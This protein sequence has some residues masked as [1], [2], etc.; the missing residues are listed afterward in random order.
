MFALWSSPNHIPIQHIGIQ[1]RKQ[2]NQDPFLNMSTM[3]HECRL[4]WKTS[5]LLF[6]IVAARFLI[7]L[8]FLLGPLKRTTK[9]VSSGVLNQEFGIRVSDFVVASMRFLGEG[10]INIEMELA[11]TSSAHGIS[12]ISP[13]MEF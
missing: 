12:N 9:L 11:P 2:A 10:H 5:L 3:G 13:I 7:F 6:F 1:L 8:I 4:Y